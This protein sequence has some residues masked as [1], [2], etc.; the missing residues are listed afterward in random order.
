MLCNLG[1]VRPGLF[2]H[3]KAAFGEYS[4]VYIHYQQTVLSRRDVHY[5][6]FKSDNFTGEITTLIEQDY[7]FPYGR[8]TLIE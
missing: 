5:G 4:F 2:L 7:S 3:R 1:K 8:M 6:L